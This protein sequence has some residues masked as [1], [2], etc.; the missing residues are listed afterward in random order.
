M[1]GVPQLYYGDEYGLQSADGTVGHSQERVD[2][3]WEK[4]SRSQ[5]ALRR[6]VSELF[7]W[8][9]T[10][11]AVAQGDFV[12]FRPDARNVYVYFRTVKGEAVMTIING[13][14][15]D[16]TV[17]WDHFME[18]TANIPRKGK[19]VITGER[20]QVGDAFVVDPGTAAILEFK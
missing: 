4:F 11:K 10:S 20:I 8:R 3:P 12:H 15:E 13:G 6:Y 9:K 17:D 2:M 5:V 19:D 14:K 7:S 18:I 16:Y 1:R